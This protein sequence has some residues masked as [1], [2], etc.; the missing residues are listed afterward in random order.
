M[1]P[2]G[3]VK[4]LQP[5]AICTVIFVTIIK[6][7]MYDKKK[8]KRRTFRICNNRLWDQHATS[9]PEDWQARQV[10]WFPAP[11]KWR[12]CFTSCFARLVYR[13]CEVDITLCWIVG[14]VVSSVKPIG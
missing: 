9:F 4:I 2:C 10:T 3:Y 8:R 1:F 6:Q 7:L 11:Q 5:V 14:S 13:E 12:R